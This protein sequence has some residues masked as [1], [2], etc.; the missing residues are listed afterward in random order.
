VV[1]VRGANID[2]TA[3]AVA[4]AAA[5]TGG[6]VRSIAPVAPGLDEVRA[7]SAGLALAAYHA[8]YAAYAAYATPWVSA[9][10]KAAGGPA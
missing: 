4:R 2:R 9:A 6:K 3:L 10:Q 5:M 7:A 8:A 1:T